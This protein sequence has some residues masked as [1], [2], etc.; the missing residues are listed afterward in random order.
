[1]FS[2]FLLVG[3]SGFLIDAA[4]T[5]VLV[6]LTI[7]PWLARVPAIVLAMTYTWVANRYFTYE[8]QTA[9]ISREVL[10]Y[11]LVA[12]GMA[13]VNYLI[14]F[15]LLGLGLRPMAAVTLATACQTIISFYCY[16]QFVFK[17]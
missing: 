12:W 7:E 5:Y 15:V 16:R 10:R 2:R 17:K 3:G 4:V 9:P 13:L 14:Y 11:A 8:V 1:M 6:L